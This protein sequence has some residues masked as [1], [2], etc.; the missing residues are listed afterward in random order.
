MLFS[1]H[2]TQH[3]DK[4]FNWS[5]LVPCPCPVL[6]SFAWVCWKQKLF[7]EIPFKAL[8]ANH[9]NWLSWEVKRHFGVLL[10]S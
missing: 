4:G 10:W 1:N 8:N 9:H 3:F 2:I 7:D 5:L 6:L